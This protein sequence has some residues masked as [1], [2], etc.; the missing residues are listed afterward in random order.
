M[1]RLNIF[2]LSFLMVCPLGAFAQT[3]DTQAE[4][5]TVVKIHRKKKQEETR[6]IKGR[7]VSQAKHEPLV[8][9]LVQSIAGEG[10]STLTEEDG[11]FELK[12]PLYSS[13]V[14]VTIPGYNMVRV[15]LNKSGELRDIVLQ[16]D[17]VRALYGTSDN[18]TNNAKA[19]SME[20]SAARN[21][22]SEIGNQ[23]GANV[24][25][26]SRSGAIAV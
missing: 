8:G 3:E 20:F 7:V 11:S 22:T 2:C 5:E 12:V 23:L 25:T 19:N 13:A 15:G 24:R 26:I 4:S 6:T 10:Y 9:V 14:T 16:S 18:I 1:K 21:V 17:A